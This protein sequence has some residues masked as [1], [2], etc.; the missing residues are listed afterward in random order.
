M[1]APIVSSSGHGSPV[2]LNPGSVSAGLVTVVEVMRA[3]FSPKRQRPCMCA[4]KLLFRL[5][6]SAAGWG[7]SARLFDPN[8]TPTA[9]ISDNPR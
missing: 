9:M 8:V 1:P 4:S 5:K 3:L 6:F 7:Y 2:I